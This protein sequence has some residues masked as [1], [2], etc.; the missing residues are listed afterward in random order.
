MYEE[1]YNCVTQHVEDKINFIDCGINIV[2]LRLNIKNSI[3][4]GHRK[5]KIYMRNFLGIYMI[6]I[7]NIQ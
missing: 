5:N 3:M 1:L 7:K 6:L 4:H 2:N